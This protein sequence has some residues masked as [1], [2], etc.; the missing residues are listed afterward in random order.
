MNHVLAQI[1]SSFISFGTLH[2]KT[3]GF[4]PWQWLMI[5]TGIL[6]FIIS[7]LF[8]YAPTRTQASSPALSNFKR[9]GFYSPTPPQMRG[10]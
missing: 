1:I 9:P 7:L 10:S 8:W 2:I 4:E 6:T 3:S 5:I